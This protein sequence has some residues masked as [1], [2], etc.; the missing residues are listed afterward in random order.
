LLKFPYNIF[1]IFFDLSLF[2]NFKTV[3]GILSKFAMSNL[4]FVT[5][6]NFNEFILGGVELAGHSWNFV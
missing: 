5:S 1:Q 4:V 6:N 3:R 2:Q